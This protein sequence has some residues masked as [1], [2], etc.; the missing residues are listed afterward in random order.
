MPQPQLRWL[1]SHKSD[2]FIAACH[3]ILC[4]SSKAN[5]SFVFQLF[6]IIS[7][8]PIMMSNSVTCPIPFFQC[9]SEFNLQKSG[10]Q[11]ED[12]LHH[13]KSLAK[14]FQQFNYYQM[15]VGINIHSWCSP[16]CPWWS[17]WAWCSSPS[18][19]LKGKVLVRDLRSLAAFRFP[20]RVRAPRPPALKGEVLTSWGAP[21]APCIA[22]AKTA[23]RARKSRNVILKARESITLSE[24]LDV[25]WV[26]AELD[27]M[28][29]DKV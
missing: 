5:N 8:R 24:S 11:F 13:S 12:T 18:W 10:D 19:A 23:M 17:P 22:K 27:G 9:S 7:M 20:L 15:E 16:W 25:W 28:R 3:S 1:M 26:Q 21:P 4:N 14:I 2:N 29:M 6:L